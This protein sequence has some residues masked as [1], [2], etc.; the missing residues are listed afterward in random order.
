MQYWLYAFKICNGNILIG[1]YD[2]LEEAKIV[3][4][5]VDINEYEYADII[6]MEW[7]KEPRWIC[8]VNF[9]KERPFV[10]RR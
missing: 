1:K 2:T 8:G 6:K 5:M 7:G 4:N 10:K 9:E 3:M